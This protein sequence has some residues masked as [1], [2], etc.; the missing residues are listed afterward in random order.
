MAVES[1]R[2][3]LIANIEEIAFDFGPYDLFIFRLGVGYPLNEVR[4]FVDSL[5]PGTQSNPIFVC[6][7]CG[8]RTI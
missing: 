6:T 2:S 4:E 8:V 7:G 3:A 1:C 5:P